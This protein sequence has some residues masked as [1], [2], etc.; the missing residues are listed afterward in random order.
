M[1][2]ERFLKFY[3]N[4]KE[5]GGDFKDEFFLLRRKVEGGME[6]FAVLLVTGSWRMRVWNWMR[7]CEEG[8]C[9]QRERFWVG[10]VGARG[11]CVGVEGQR[12][13][14]GL[15]EVMLSMVE[16]AIRRDTLVVR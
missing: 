11:H 7:V 12:E 4:A 6:S 13:E 14:T 15:G 5:G 1:S 3:L 2:Y 9:L 10:C 16:N 8:E